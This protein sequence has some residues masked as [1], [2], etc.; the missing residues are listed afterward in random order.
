MAFGLSVEIFV[1]DSSIQYQ[2][3]VVRRSSIRKQ[4]AL[5]FFDLLVL[6]AGVLCVAISITYRKKDLLMNIAY[7]WKDTFL[8]TFA[9]SIRAIVQK[10]RVTIGLVISNYS[11]VLLIQALIVLVIGTYVWFP[12]LTERAVFSRGWNALADADRSTLQDKFGCCGYFDASDHPVVG[13]NFCTLPQ[14]TFLNSL[15][16]T[17]DDNAHFFCVSPITNF[18]DYA[19]KNAFRWAIYG[20]MAPVLC[21]L[22]ASISVIFKRNE[23]ESFK[24]IDAKQVGKGF[25]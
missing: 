22:L 16:L 10:N 15:D 5:V 7:S 21:F 4:A 19:L 24:K 3:Q 1:R 11:Y 20:F 12:T 23:E 6:A 2:F 17:N 18:A 9:F 13:G 25:V 14:V 8:V